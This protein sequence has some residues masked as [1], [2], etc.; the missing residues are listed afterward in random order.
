MAT[1]QEPAFQAIVADSA[2]ANIFPILVRK[3]P[4]QS[5]LPALLLPGGLVAV[6][7]IYC[8]DYTHIR[9]VDFVASIA[10]RP[11]FLIHGTSDD[12]I[13]PANMDMLAAAARKPPLAD[14][15]TWLVPGA[16]HAQS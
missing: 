3:F 2:Y 4:E 15:Q 10:P 16:Q 14:V 5:H 11:L 12:F 1:A 7:A 13:P 8:I 9:S 6:R